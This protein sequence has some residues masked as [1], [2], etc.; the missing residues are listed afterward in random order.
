[1]TNHRAEEKLQLYLFCL[2]RYMDVVILDTT[3][4][5]TPGGSN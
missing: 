2:T 5:R 4:Q 3:F 1:M